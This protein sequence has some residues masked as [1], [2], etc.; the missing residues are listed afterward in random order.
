MTY[1]RVSTVAL[2]FC[3]GAGD[4]AAES[5]AFELAVMVTS[6]R[7]PIGSPLILMNSEK[8]RG[9]TDDMSEVG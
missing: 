3:L 9:V 2:L 4:P 5:C 7:D 1:L 6:H 8:W